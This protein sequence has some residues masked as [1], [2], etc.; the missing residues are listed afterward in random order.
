MDIWLETCTYVSTEYFTVS[1]ENSVHKTTQCTH[2]TL[3]TNIQIC[4][5]V[6]I[7]TFNCI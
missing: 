4:A 1:K 6:F 3:Y 2:C 5:Y 7:A